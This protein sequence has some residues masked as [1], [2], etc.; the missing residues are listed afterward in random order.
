VLPV[1]EKLSAVTIRN[2]LFAVAERIEKELREERPCLLR[3]RA[4][5]RPKPPRRLFE[6]LKSQG[7][8][9]V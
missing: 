5:V 7:M 3:F 6:L 8:T 2:H 1:D 9:R 4:D